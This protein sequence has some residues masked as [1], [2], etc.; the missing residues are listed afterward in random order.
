MERFN[1]R[2]TKQYWEGQRARAGAVDEASD[3]DLLGNVCHAGAPIW[4]NDYY[5]RYQRIVFEELLARTGLGAGARALDV[6]CGAGRWCRLLSL[7]GFSVEGIDLQEELLARSRK[8]YPDVRFHCVPIQ[9][10]TPE[11]PFDLVTTVTVLQHLPPDEQSRAIARI[12]TLV[13]PGGYALCLE[14]VSDQTVHV[15]AKTKDEWQRAFEAVGFSL[16]TRKPYDYSPFIRMSS[17]AIE[18]AFGLAR[19]LGVIT[20]PAEAGVPR[21]PEGGGRSAGGELKRAVRTAAWGARRV[22]TAL[23]D[24]LEPLLL[25]Y[26]VA[27]PTVH[28]GFLFRKG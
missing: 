22:A 13:S 9:D 8:R 5:A 2:E 15:F 7:R 28:C 23:D 1:W 16:V 12:A 25:R 18:A 10:F 26:D 17:G 3:P 4:F 11:R 20:V 19:R 24:R 27:A 14:N 21:A 6:G